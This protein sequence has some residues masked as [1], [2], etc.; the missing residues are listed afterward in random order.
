[1]ATPGEFDPRLT[2]VEARLTAVEPRLT[3]VEARARAARVEAGV[4]AA[5][6]VARPGP[7]RP[8]RHGRREPARDQRG[9]RPDGGAVD[10]P[11]ERVERWPR[12]TGHWAWAARHRSPGM[13]RGTGDHRPGADGPHPASQLP[14]RGSPRSAA[15]HRPR[16]AG[17]AAPV[18][19]QWAARHQSPGGAPRGTVI[20]GRGAHRPHPASQL[21]FRR[22]QHSAA[23]HRPRVA[24]RAAPVTGRCAARHQSPAGEHTGHI[25]P[26]SSLSGDH[27]TRPPQPSP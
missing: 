6:R 14:R 8:R 5:G 27:R 11:E 17:R 22:S 21:P 4:L 15:R 9:G 3:A 24:G 16:A 26:R 1:M 7:R 25:R 12:G 13:G 2:A 19:G 23:R 18:I 10:R 20:T